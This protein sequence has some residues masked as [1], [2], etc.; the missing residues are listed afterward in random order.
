MHDERAVNPLD[1]VAHGKSKKGS[2][3]LHS[4]GEHGTKVY[5]VKQLQAADRDGEEGDTRIVPMM[6]EYTVFNVAQ[7]EGLPEKIVN[8]A[9][10]ALRNKDER[11][12][13]ADAFMASTRADIRDKLVTE[14]VSARQSA[15]AAAKSQDLEKARS[16]SRSVAGS[17]P[18]ADGRSSADKPTGLRDEIAMRVRNAGGRA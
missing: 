13:L 6:R 8:P 12:A 10:V 7:C 16:A 9:A 3:G 11:E 2:S 1:G 17:P 5:F 4:R 14:Q 18:S 15:A